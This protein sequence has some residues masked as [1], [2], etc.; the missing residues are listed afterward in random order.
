VHQCLFNHSIPRS[1]LYSMFV[2]SG[3]DALL[4]ILQRLQSPQSMF[5]QINRL[6]EAEHFQR[7][8]S[9]SRGCLCS[10]DDLRMQPGG[11]RWCTVWTGTTA[12]YGP[13]LPRPD[14]QEVCRVRGHD[15]IRRADAAH[16]GRRAGGP[17]GRH[18]VWSEQGQKRVCSDPNQQASSR[19]RPS[20]R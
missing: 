3:C 11:A 19:H 8:S 10:K 7:S 9:V 6:L 4:Y 18:H 1:L 17:R 12:A 13:H 2:S 20:S 5:Y 15:G 14:P 16:G